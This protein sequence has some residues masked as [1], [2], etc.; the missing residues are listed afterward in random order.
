MRS[1]PYLGAAR[2]HVCLSNTGMFLRDPAKP[3][4]KEELEPAGPF[5][6]FQKMVRETPEWMHWEMLNMMTVSDLPD[7]VVAGYGAP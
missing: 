4:T 7:E 5:A 6:A 3:I 2:R 1:S